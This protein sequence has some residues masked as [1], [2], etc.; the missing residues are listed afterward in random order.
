VASIYRQPWSPFYKCVVRRRITGALAAV[1][2]V[3]QTASRRVRGVGLF[4]LALSISV[5]GVLM[6]YWQAM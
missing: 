6:L 4:V 1:A 3:A 5:F 2:V